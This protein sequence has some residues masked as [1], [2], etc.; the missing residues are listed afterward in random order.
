MFL[1]RKVR[2]AYSSVFF[3]LSGML[4]VDADGRYL[5]LMD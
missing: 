3:P 4:S 2:S 5:V 1:R